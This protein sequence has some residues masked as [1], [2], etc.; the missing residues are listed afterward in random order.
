M[1]VSG[2]A[3]RL[4]V[5]ENLVTLDFN[6]PLAGKTLVFEIEVLEVKKSEGGDVE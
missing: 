5:E 6:H 1:T 2:I 4:K 3:K